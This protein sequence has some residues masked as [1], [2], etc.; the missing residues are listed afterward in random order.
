MLFQL[1]LWGL[2]AL[3]MFSLLGVIPTPTPPQRPI[4]TYLTDGFST[5]V[6]FANNPTIQ[7]WITLEG[8]VKAGGF[9]TEGPIKIG[10]MHAKRMRVMAAKKLVT[11]Q[12][13]TLTCFYDPAV[14]TP[15]VIIGGQLGLETTITLTFPD[16]SSW[17]FY[18][19]LNKFEVSDH[20]EG[21]APT[22]SCEIIAISRDPYGTGTSSIGGIDGE[23]LPLYTPE[24]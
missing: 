24:E 7:L 10:T 22:A 14:M 3:W 4:G 9:D 1:I 23:E 20:K 11:H 15:L 19:Y 13:T 18:G 21:T 17:A 16:G 5:L 6:T 2:V 12:P 8:G